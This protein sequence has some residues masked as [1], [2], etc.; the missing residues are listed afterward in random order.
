MKLT[1]KHNV[2]NSLNMSTVNKKLKLAFI[3]FLLVPALFLTSCDRGEDPG[4]GPIATPAF[5][6]MK[7]YMVANDLD[8]DHVIKNVNG[9]KFVQPAPANADL[10]AFLNKYYIIDIRKSNDYG[11][12]HIEGAH[13]TPFADILIEAAKA[14]KQILVVCYSGQTA[15]YATSLLRMYGYD[16]AQ[17]LKWGMSGWS[18]TTATSWNN[19]I[20]KEPAKGSPNWNSADAPKTNT[21]EDPLISS[22]SKDGAEILR[23]RVEAVVAAGFKNV[24]NG[25]VLASPSSYFV[26]NYY[27]ET[28]YKGFGHIANA[29]RVKEDLLLKDNGYL[30]MDPDGGAKVVT[31]C[32]TGQT[33]AVVTAWLNV[34]GYDAYSLLFGMNGLYNTNPEWSVNPANT[35][36][37]WG[38]GANPKNLPLK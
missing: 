2:N 13:N 36:N 38:V 29:Y 19:Q 15:C 9:I 23:Q 32:Y 12:S 14:N 21:Y 10:A 28:D 26:N 34:L 30:G 33:S 6:L 5:E 27:S 7:D 4:E 3:A 37:Q 31:Y 8:L 11:T 16:D 18:P 17:A 20:G 1:K 35:K 22:L 25:D 24:T